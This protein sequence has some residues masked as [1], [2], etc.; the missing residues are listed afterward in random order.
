[1]GKVTLEKTTYCCFVFISLATILIP[2]TLLLTR[3]ALLNRAVDL[4]LWN[5]C[6]RPTPNEK[7]SPNQPSASSWTENA[8]ETIK[9]PKCWSWRMVT[10]LTPSWS[11][12][13]DPKCEITPSTRLVLDLDSFG[14]NVARGGY[15][16]LSVPLGR[17]CFK[18]TAESLVACLV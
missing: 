15:K 4:L 3:Y 18:T 8:L 7:A 10:R 5:R 11:R 12:S 14:R 9:Q 1:M 13:A 2:Y 17:L 6:S 16:E